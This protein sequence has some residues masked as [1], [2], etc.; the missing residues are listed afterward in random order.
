MVVQSYLSGFLISR[1]EVLSDYTQSYLDSFK[2]RNVI[3]LGRRIQFKFTIRER[4][5]VKKINPVI[6]KAKV[7]DAEEIVFM[8]KEIYKDSYPYKEME[9][10]ENVR[11]MIASENIEWLIFEHP[12]T[13]ESCGCFT[14]VL[15]FEDKKGYTRG[16]IMK[17]KY[18]GKMDVIKAF[19]A[20]F[21][22]MYIKY[23]GKILRWYGES[24]TAHSKSQYC[25]RPGGFRP[26]AF[27]P[28]KD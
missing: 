6:R 14:L 15:D 16:F 10:I 21:I 18:E 26:V 28:N 8:Y 13:K 20:S 24:R 2:F 9:N 11:Q 1:T 5:K 25:M 27:L 7:K 19:L 12:I 3:D 4:Q 22:A 23:E 17:K